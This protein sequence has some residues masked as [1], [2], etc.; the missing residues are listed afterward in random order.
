[1]NF[2]LED[3]LTS[4]FVMEEDR[5]A[6]TQVVAVRYLVVKSRKGSESELV[7]LRKVLITGTDVADAL[8]ECERRL[9]SRVGQDLDHTFFE[10]FT[11]QSGDVE[12]V[13]TRWGS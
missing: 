5:A 12:V 4:Y 8:L 13:C 10:G 1:M 3:G 11:V 2:E 7:I 6:M 9:R